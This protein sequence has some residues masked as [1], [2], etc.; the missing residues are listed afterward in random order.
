MNNQKIEKKFDK[1]ENVNLEKIEDEVN[2]LHEVLISYAEEIKLKEVEESDEESLVCTTKKFDDCEVN[3]ETFGCGVLDSGCSKTVCGTDWLETYLDMLTESEL[4]EVKF[5]ESDARFKFGNEQ[6]FKSSDRVTFPAVLG[7][8]SVLIASD[9]VN[10]NIPLLLSKSTMKKAKTVIDFENDSV[11]MFGKKVP[12]MYTSKGGHY[13]VSLNRK[14]DLMYGDV[15]I[16]AS[17]VYFVN[18]KKIKTLSASEKNKVA[19]KV[20]KQFCHCS[21]KRLRKLFEDAGIKDKEMLSMLEQVRDNCKLC[22]KYGSTPPKPIVTMPIATSF[23]ESVAMDL[24][25]INSKYILHLIDHLT[26]FSAACVVSSK[27]KEVIIAAVLKIWIG[28]FGC[29]AKIL[30]DNGGEFSNDDFREMGEKLNTR[31]T[32]TAAESPW[33]NGINERHNGLLGEMILKTMEDTDCAL[34]VAVSWSICAKNSLANVNGYSP[35]QLVFGKNPILPSI[36]HDKLPALENQCHS[37]IMRENLNAMYSAKKNFVCL[38]SSERLRRALRSKTRTH[39]GKIFQVGQSVYYK[40]PKCGNV[41]KGPGKVIGV[42]GEVVMIRHGGQGVR[43]H[44]SMVKIENSEFAE[45]SEDVADIPNPK[46]AKDDKSDQGQKSPEKRVQFLENID[47]EETPDMSIVN[48]IS[49]NME[50]ENSAIQEQVVEREN[51]SLTSGCTEGINAGGESNNVQS[52]KLPTMKSNVMFKL[53]GSEQWREGKILSRGGKATGKF[54]KWLNVLDT[55]TNV[56]EGINWDKVEEWK[57]MHTEEVLISEVHNVDQVLQAKYDE[58]EKWRGYEAF[59]EVENE[60]QKTISTRW[61]CSEKDGVVKARL[62]ARGFEEEELK[63]RVDSPTCSKSNLRLVVALSASK[64]WRI[65]SLDFQSAF[66]QGEDITTDIFL[67]PP[68]EANTKK[69]WKLRKPVYGLKQSSRKWYNKISSELLKK[70]ISKCKLDEALFYWHQD[71]ELKGLI[72]GH[73]DDFF[74][75]GMKDMKIGVMDSLV[76]TFNISS[77]QHDSFNFIGLDMKQ[78]DSGVEIDQ[79][80]YAE[81]IDYV[82]CANKEDKHRLLSDDEKSPLRSA[83]GQLSWLANQTRPDIAY[84]VCQLSV[85]YKNATVTDIINANKTI[86]KVKHNNLK[87]KFP[88]LQQNGRYILK[89]Y[90]D[91]SFNN[92]PNGGSQ[93]GFIIFLCDSEDNGAPIQWQSKKIRR[94]AKSTLAAECLAMEDAVDAAFYLKCVLLEILQASVENIRVECFIDNKSLYD[95]LHSSTNVKEEKRLILDIALIKEMLQKNEINSVTLVESKEQLA[96]C[97]TKQGASSEGLRDVIAAGCLK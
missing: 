95:N 88:K 83:I 28:I 56:A 11:K 82:P 80:I 15:C 24:K 48:E 10:T 69:L 23:N 65:N 64:E 42:D 27:K 67:K 78:K 81:G 43:V 39:T 26:R 74:W 96:D 87:L 47:E 55:E 38:E 9:V 7:G 45:E 75:S 63:E 54:P 36:L 12:L 34:D 46:E 37:E 13:C 57:E 3:R 97:L 86:K 76:K 22:E 21:G 52:Q 25:E 44:S 17:Q 16:D 14:T 53:A 59:V 85:R 4:K 20:H 89:V 62:V 50:A 18:L 29:P 31:I 84:D 30:S 49:Q 41:W 77:D 68:K 33:S 19:V 2:R 91:S 8:K 35:H 60:G 58:M 70:G 72:A 71:K 94:V 5:E 1:T 66:L 32:T 90:S 40:R 51:D 92:L 6:V 61:V 73:V 93:G 79:I